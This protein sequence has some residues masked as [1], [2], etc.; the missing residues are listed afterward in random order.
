MKKKSLVRTIKHHKIRTVPIYSTNWRVLAL[1]I[2]TVFAIAVL[3]SFYSQTSVLKTLKSPTSCYDSDNGLNYFV[4]GSVTPKESKTEYKDS[5]AIRDLGTILR[6]KEVSSCSI[7]NTSIA[8]CYVRERYCATSNS[9]IASVSI[10]D[11]KEIK[12]IGCS[13]GAGYR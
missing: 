9:T 8:N 11:C 1:T 3:Y 6:Y 13:N 10:K 2:L 12:C 7:Y 4:S 5:C